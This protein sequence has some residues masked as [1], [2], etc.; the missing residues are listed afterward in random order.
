MNVHIF[1][2]SLKLPSLL[3]KDEHI[4]CNCDIAIAP[5]N[6]VFHLK[7]TPRS[8]SDFGLVSL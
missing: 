5:Y 3:L 8:Q 2:I 1:I 4:K 6:Y 7:M